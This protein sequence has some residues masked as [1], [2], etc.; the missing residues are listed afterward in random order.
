MKF[1]L[2][3]SGF[4][5]QYVD[6]FPYYQKNFLKPLIAAGH[7]VDVFIHGW[8]ANHDEYS[9]IKLLYNAKKIHFEEYT[10]EIQSKIF[11]DIPNGPCPLNNKYKNNITGMYY[12]IYNCNELK[13]QYAVENKITY[14]ICVHSR[15]DNIYFIYPS[16]TV[17]PNTI[18]FENCRSNICDHFYYGDNE[19]MNKVASIYTLLSTLTNQTHKRKWPG[20]GAEHLLHYA[21]TNYFKLCLK[22]GKKRGLQHAIYYMCK[23]HYNKM[24]TL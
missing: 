24:L 5:R 22:K 13:K 14:D 2:C 20:V 12:N 9:A 8:H 15:L 4:T 3:L 17:S 16:F 11:G 1:A 10:N 19:S 7:Q 6:C 21:I 18:Y 23:R